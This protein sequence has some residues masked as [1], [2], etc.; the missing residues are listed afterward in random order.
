MSDGGDKFW[1]TLSGM[2]VGAAA[3]AAAMFFLS[4]RSGKENRKLMQDKISEAK[5]YMEEE[6]ALM[7]AKVQEIFGEVNDLTTSLF[8]DAKR[9]WNNQVRAFEKSMD[10]IDKGRYQEMVDNVME[11]LQSSKRY[12]NTDLA[13]MKRYLSSEWRKFSQMID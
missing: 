13:K 4:P 10:K 2:L 12:D 11:T 3:G 5:D 6:R 8:E 7:E 9:L 1:A